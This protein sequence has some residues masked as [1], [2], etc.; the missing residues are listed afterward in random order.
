MT[1]QEI[2]YSLG[3]NNYDNQPIQ[4][5]ADN[6]NEFVE[7]ILN[8]RSHAKGEI[9]F[10]SQFKRGPHKDRLKYPNDG[11]YRC[12]EY[13]EPKRF[14]SLDFDGFKDVHA[15]DKT[16][17]ALKDFSGFGYTTW[18]HKADAPRARAVLELNRE[19]TRDEGIKLGEAIEA[20]LIQVVGSGEIVFDECVYRAEQPVYGPPLDA[21]IYKFNGDVLNVDELLSKF[22]KSQTQIN[23]SPSKTVDPTSQSYNRLTRESL[24][25]V[26]AKVDFNNNAIWS[27]IAN[28]LARVYGDGGRDC[29]IKYS[30]GGYAN[31]S[32]P[33]FDISEVNQRF[34]RALDEV[35]R[36]PNGVG[37]RRICEH[38]GVD[39]T[40]LEFEEKQLTEEELATQRAFF[41][42]LPG[43]LKTEEF[44]DVSDIGSAEVE[45]SKPP[46]IFPL[47]NKQNKPAQVTENISA[48]LKHKGIVARYNQIKKNTEIL[49]PG[50]NCVFDEQDNTALTLLID[51]V[52]KSGLSAARVDEMTSAIAA[53]NPYC[54]VQSYIESKPWDGH[55]RIPQFCNQISTSHVGMAH[56]LIS[57]WM[58][59]AVAAAYAKK[60]LSG[61]GVLV[62]TGSQG[63][64]KTRLLRDLTADIPDVLLEGATLNPDDKDSVF[65]ACSHW[66][67]EL[68]ELDATFKK[69]EIAQLKAFLTKS[70]DTLRKPYARKDS[71]YPRRTVFAGTV[72]DLQFLHDPTG[73]RRFWPLS[74]DAITRDP[75]IDYQQLWA[76]MKFK[77]DAGETWHLSKIEMQQLNIY[78]EQFTVTEPAIEKLLKKYDFASC[79]KWQEAL[80]SDICT[81]IDMPYA[82]K[83]EI[84]KLASAIRKY[85][86][87]QKPR[88][89]NGKKY[90]YVPA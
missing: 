24:E 62:L 3:K 39:P 33:K 31:S 61:A 19:V 36:R 66:I 79:V 1:T 80:M 47:R 7:A 30:E 28:A 55:S 90:H 59:Q 70:T 32:Y 73:N 44:Q 69:S 83:G 52:V 6:F 20:F 53:Q 58:L 23:I 11:N 89:S 50:M 88:E 42:S 82:T 27:D 9:Y 37:I 18:S 75:S 84:Q 16:M 51:E 49:I 81:A 57:K 68:G 74:V 17:I 22:I 21:D 10:C 4:L 65:T 5:V 63:L 48:V 41:Q 71:T 8:K 85:N 77:Y 34:D 56:F 38:A 29:F 60:G 86:G 12:S 14:A 78:S 54:P 25:K 64:G 72:N 76:E 45:L 35:A 43:Y 67:V 13:A 26:L 87:G 2:K 15:F 40:S 46:F